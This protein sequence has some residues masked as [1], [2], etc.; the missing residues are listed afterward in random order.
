MKERRTGIKLIPELGELLSHR[1]EGGTH[2][3]EERNWVTKSE[4]RELKIRWPQR[5]SLTF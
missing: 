4:L 5:D 2:R 3:S 1:A